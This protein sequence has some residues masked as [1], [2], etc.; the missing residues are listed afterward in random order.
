MRY[1]LGVELD[2]DPPLE[3]KLTVQFRWLAQPQH[4]VD[5]ATSKT[6]CGKPVGALIEEAAIDWEE[7]PADQVCPACVT[8]LNVKAR[9]GPSPYELPYHRPS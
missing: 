9:V 2:R 7:L 8:A 5:R 3:G 1:S 4:G 6:L